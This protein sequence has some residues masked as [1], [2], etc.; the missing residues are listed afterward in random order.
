M[1]IRQRLFPCVIAALMLVGHVATPTMAQR[2]AVVD[3]TADEDDAGKAQEPAGE[4]SVLDTQPIL[5]VDPND[6]YKARQPEKKEA[7]PILVRE[8]K[9]LFDRE[10]TIVRKGAESHFVFASGERPMVLLACKPLERAENLSEFGKKPLAFL[11]AGIVCEYRGRNYLLL[12][13]DARVSDGAAQEPGAPPRP[14]TRPSPDPGKKKSGPSD[15]D[16]PPG[17]SDLSVPAAQAAP[18]VPGTQAPP[19]GPPR[20][21]REGK[22]LMDRE[23]RVNRLGDQTVFI[24]DTGDT[25]VVL[26]PNKKLERMETLTDFGRKPMRFRISGRVSEYR[27]RNHLSMTKMVVI[28]KAVEKL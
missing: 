13:D 24:F 11:A 23:G 6:P 26:L 20:L 3:I 28:P 18:T 16:G 8:G 7:A 10:G 2:P 4:N 5:E 1:T 14:A 19:A 12:E 15:R 27:G 17:E 22:R 9:R 21:Y 25:P